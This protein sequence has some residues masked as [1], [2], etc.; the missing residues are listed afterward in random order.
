MQGNPEHQIEHEHVL[1]LLVNTPDAVF[2]RI[3]RV[4]NRTYREMGIVTAYKQRADAETFCN[5]WRA[6]CYLTVKSYSDALLD[7]L[8]HTLLAETECSEPLM[9]NVCFGERTD[10]RYKTFGK[11][12][13]DDG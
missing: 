13:L 1:E 11:V 12:S 6:E 7:G 8:G 9:V 3:Y 5:H 10:N 2:G 4:R